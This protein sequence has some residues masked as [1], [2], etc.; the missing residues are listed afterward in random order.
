M[1]ASKLF[2]DIVDNT[3]TVE[4]VNQLVLVKNAA[5]PGTAKKM[6]VNALK[7][8]G[9]WAKANPGKAAV[10]GGAG[11]GAGVTAKSTI[12][13]RVGQELS[14]GVGADPVVK[15]LTNPAKMTGAEKVNT[16]IGAAAA[17]ASGAGLY[18]LLGAM[19]G[20]K[21]RKVLRAIMASL[22]AGAT[23]Y[24][25]WRAADNYQKA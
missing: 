14:G 5:I 1:N 4:L 17:L 9:N 12:G 23:G 20:L 13:K 6:I 15:A 25:A 2:T 10:I 19:P 18:S 24:A 11:V 16:G 3:K 22:G 21:R 7:G 8:T